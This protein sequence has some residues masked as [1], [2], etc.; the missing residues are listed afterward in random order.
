[1]LTDF[2]PLKSRNSLVNWLLLLMTPDFIDRA[3]GKEPF[4]KNNEQDSFRA[5]LKG[6]FSF[7]TLEWVGI[8]MHCRDLIRRLL[9]VDPILRMTAIQTTKH[10]WI[11]GEETAKHILPEIPYRLECF[12][13]ICKERVGQKIGFSV[14]LANSTE[15]F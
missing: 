12:N 1:M 14:R 7:D 15:E 11:T 8:S 10:K 3:S 5:I 2:Q 13:H 9:V 4:K 6:D